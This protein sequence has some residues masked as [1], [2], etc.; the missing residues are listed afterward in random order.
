MLYAAIVRKVTG[1]NRDFC[2]LLLYLGEELYPSFMACYHLPGELKWCS[3]DGDS[4]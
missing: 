4:E 1:G 2:A 3:L